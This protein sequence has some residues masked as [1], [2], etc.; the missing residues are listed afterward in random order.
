ME[1]SADG[2][3]HKLPLWSDPAGFLPQVFESVSRNLS[4]WISEPSLRER[5]PICN[6]ELP[7]RGHLFFCGHATALLV[8]LRIPSDDCLCLRRHAWNVI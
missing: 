7:L 4:F 1:Y 5:N 6:L 2:W 3:I 8:T